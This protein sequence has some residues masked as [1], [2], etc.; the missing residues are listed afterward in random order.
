MSSCAKLVLARAIL[1]D[2]HLGSSHF[3][4]CPFISLEEKQASEDVDA[5][6][7]NVAEAVPTDTASDVKKASD[8]AAEAA[9]KEKAAQEEAAAKKAAEEAK[10]KAEAGT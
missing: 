2:C 3:M 9:A 1:D 10:A 5:A 8:E 7:T 6:K 4:P